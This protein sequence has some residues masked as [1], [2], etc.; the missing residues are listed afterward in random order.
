ML[1][2]FELRLAELAQL[3][4]QPSQWLIKLILGPLASI[5]GKGKQLI[6]QYQPSAAI[7]TKG[8]SQLLDGVRRRLSTTHDVG[9]GG[10]A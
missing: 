2:Q 9:D 4:D 3:I 7:T 10:V 8:C 1:N 6:L 5:A